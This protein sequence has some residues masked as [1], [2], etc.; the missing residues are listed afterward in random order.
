MENT[1]GPI[2]YT[3]LNSKKN[4]FEKYNSDNLYFLE[5]MSVSSKKND[6]NVSNNDEIVLRIKKKFL[7]IAIIATGISAAYIGGSK[8]V[9]ENKEFERQHNIERE[10]TDLA[11]KDQYSDDYRFHRN[12]VD[13]NIDTK[14]VGDESI[15]MYKC[16]GIAKD[17]YDVCKMDESLLDVLLHNVYFDLQFNRLNNM[18]VIYNS[19]K[20]LVAKDS[21]M[22][23]T[24]QKLSN[25][26]TFLD[27]LVNNGFLD[28]D[29]EDYYDIVKSA[30]KKE[31]FGDLSKMDQDNILKLIEDYEKS[32]RKLY[33]EFEDEIG[34]LTKSRW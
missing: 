28:R 15:T 30:S 21:S 7:Q 20:Y 26:N 11:I 22:E 3:P 1:D 17:I 5:N 29:R 10:L 8:I 24:N 23:S 19:L 27:Y 25:S 33:F 16:D 34:D 14:I 6:E 2:K 13:Q 18:E 9:K 12:I 4:N 31:A 32:G